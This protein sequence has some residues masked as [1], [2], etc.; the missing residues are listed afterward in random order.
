MVA[1]PGRLHRALALDD[2]L[3]VSTEKPAAVQ[4]I[5]WTPDSKGTQTTTRLL[6]RMSWIHKEKKQKTGIPGKP[7][8][9]KV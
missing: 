4:C 2:E 5:R 1:N 8:A 3:V 6:S 9:I 7:D